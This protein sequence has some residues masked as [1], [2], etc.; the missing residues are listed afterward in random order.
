MKNKILS[1]FILFLIANT[2]IVLGFTSI[3][4]WNT[5]E[6]QETN[7]TS[8]ENYLTLEAESAILIEQ[9]TRKNSF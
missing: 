3:P 4:L 2:Y 5:F 9:S 7:A 8:I 1:F 6:T